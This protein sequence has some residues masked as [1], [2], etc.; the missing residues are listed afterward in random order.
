M[1]GMKHSE[2]VERVLN[3]NAKISPIL[4]K[5][6]RNSSLIGKKWTK[7]TCNVCNCAD[8]RKHI[9]YFINCC[10]TW[11]LEVI[12]IRMNTVNIQEN[13]NEGN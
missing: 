9:S 12:T 10:M 3:Q 13:A 8:S 4:L 5:R 2:Y 11:I 6:A 7:S 1:D